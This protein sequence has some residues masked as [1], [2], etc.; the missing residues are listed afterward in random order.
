MEKNKQ[1]LESSNRE[2]ASEMKSLQQGKM[3]SEHKR[4]KL[5]AQL[6]ELTARLTEGERAKGELLDRSHKLQVSWKRNFTIERKKERTN[7]YELF[8]EIDS[9][10]DIM[11]DLE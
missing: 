11:I 7:S 9:I 5:E 6:Q 10:L 1:S 4:K 3:E 8:I 2:M